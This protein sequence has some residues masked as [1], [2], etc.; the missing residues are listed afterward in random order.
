MI[1]LKQ[2]GVFSTHRGS[3]K[4]RDIVEQGMTYGTIVNKKKS[5]RKPSVFRLLRPSFEDI[6]Y[7]PRHTTPSYPKDC[8]AITLLLD[9]RVSSV[10]VDIP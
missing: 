10:F 3:I 5:D 2:D 9:V 8:A 6:P 4:H 1:K 7:F